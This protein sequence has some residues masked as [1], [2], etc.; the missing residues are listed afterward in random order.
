MVRDEILGAP[1]DPGEIAHA[2]LLAESERVSECQPRRIRKR[3]RGHR[4]RLVTRLRIAQS[5]SHGLC[6]RKIDAQQIT[7]VEIHIDIVMEV[8]TSRSCS[9]GRL[10]L[11][12]REEAGAAA[13]GAEEVS[14]IAVGGLERFDAVDG[15]PADRVLDAAPDREPEQGREDEDGEGVQDQ[16]V[17]ELDAREDVVRRGTGLR[18]QARAVRTARRR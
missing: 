5:P 11:C 14:P 9:S 16:F 13:L 8:D 3:L 6:P 4:S 2:Q 7:T 17:V 15:H 12:V 1:A 18:D 10:S